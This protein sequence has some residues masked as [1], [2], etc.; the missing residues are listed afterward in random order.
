MRKGITMG[1]LGRTHRE[2]P[3]GYDCGW[4]V[5]IRKEK[6]SGQERQ[7]PIPQGSC[8]EGCQWGRLGD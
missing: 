6:L 8:V 4:K 2:R 1:L 5:G 3:P 7:K